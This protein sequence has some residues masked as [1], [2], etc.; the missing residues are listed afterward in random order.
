MAKKNDQDELDRQMQEA[1]ARDDFATFQRLHRQSSAARGG[2]SYIN[3]L[4]AN[5][6]LGTRDQIDSGLTQIPYTGPLQDSPASVAS[7][8]AKTASLA[9]NIREYGVGGKSGAPTIQ[10][11]KGRNIPLTRAQADNLQTN[12]YNQFLTDIGVDP[13]SLGTAQLGEMQYDDRGNLISQK[14]EVPSLQEEQDAR[15]LQNYASG[16]HNRARIAADRA[17][18]QGQPLYGLN[19]QQ[20]ADDAY[21]TPNRSSTANLQYWLNKLRSTK[22]VQ[23]SNGF[24]SNSQ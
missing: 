14:L 11:E 5:D 8:P 2:A 15:S 13:N 1:A 18:R 3:G 22:Q 16:Q 10:D 21:S 20:Q 12:K 7:D 19:A 9:E 17:T 23:Q 4:P 6:A 24:A